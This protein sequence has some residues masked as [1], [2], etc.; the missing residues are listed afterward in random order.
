MFI[1]INGNRIDKSRVTANHGMNFGQFRHD[2]LSLDNYK[3]CVEKKEFIELFE[4]DFIQA[5][6][7]I[8]FDDQFCNETSEF[9]GSDYANLEQ[10]F[11]FKDDL[12]EIIRIYIE[13]KLK[14]CFLSLLQQVLLLI[15]L[16]R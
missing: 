1:S 2:A 6:D 8:K 9:S 7:E 12:A 14:H 13:R 16:I 3:L 4:K 10:M 11:D 15:A 5:R